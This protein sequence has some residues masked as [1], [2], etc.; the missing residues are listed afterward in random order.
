MPHVVLTGDINCEKVFEHLDE[1]FIKIPT[2]ILKTTNHYLDKKKQAV[3]VESLAIDKGVKIDFLIL[4]NNRED[5]VVIRLSP[6]T[7]Q[8]E[9]TDG[10]KQLLAEVAKQLLQKTPEIKVGKSNLQDFL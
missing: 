10:V 2:G 3:L 6:Y 1:I 5:G 8:I 4:I 9:K 7:D